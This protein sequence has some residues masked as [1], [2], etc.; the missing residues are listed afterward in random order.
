[1]AEEIDVLVLTPAKEPDPKPLVRGVLGVEPLDG[2][3]FGVLEG[4]R[5]GVLEAELF[6]VGV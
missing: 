1:M 5:D 3:R 6:G 2:V 4:V